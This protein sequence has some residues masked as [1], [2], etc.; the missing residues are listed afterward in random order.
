MVFVHFTLLLKITFSGSTILLHIQCRWAARGPSRPRSARRRHF[1]SSRSWE[2]APPLT[3]R[4]VLVERKLPIANRPYVL[5][6]TVLRDGPARLSDDT[7]VIRIERAQEALTRDQ[8][9]DEEELDYT[10]R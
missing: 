4:E 3:L 7:L 10:N 8:S 6:N 9:Y 5:M 1:E 2:P